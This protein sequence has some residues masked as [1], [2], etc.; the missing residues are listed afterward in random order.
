MIP[1]KQVEDDAQVTEIVPG[2][3]GSV[4]AG[5]IADA[6]RDEF[7]EKLTWADLTK[8]LGESG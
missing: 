7:S 6:W 3:E 5:D 8:W 2:E 4:P 1:I